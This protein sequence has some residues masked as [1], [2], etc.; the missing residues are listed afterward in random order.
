MRAQ[1]SAY[2]TPDKRLQNSCQET[3]TEMIEYLTESF[4]LISSFIRTP[5]KER[6]FITPWREGYSQSRISWLLHIN[7]MAR[8]GTLYAQDNNFLG[9]TG[10]ALSYEPQKRPALRP[11]RTVNFQLPRKH[12]VR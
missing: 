5:Q 3:T 11:G 1:Q 9:N 2:N 8:F 4:W 12:Q 6:M 10:D 7:V